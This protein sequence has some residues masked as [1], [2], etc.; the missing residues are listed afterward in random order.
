MR[1]LYVLLWVVWMYAWHDCMFTLCVCVQPCAVSSSMCLHMHVLCVFMHV[2]VCTFECTRVCV[3]MHIRVRVC[4][5]KV[6]VCMWLFTCWQEN[7]II[8]MLLLLYSSKAWTLFIP[9]AYAWRFVTQ[10]LASK[11]IN[12]SPVVPMV[13]KSLNYCLKHDRM[14][15]RRKQGEDKNYLSC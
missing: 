6:G 3:C 13:I 1:A 2:Y 7:V 15:T 11:C 14:Q 12:I 9:T 10:F 8:L 5:C 4:V